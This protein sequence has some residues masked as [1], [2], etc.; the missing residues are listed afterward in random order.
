MMRNLDQDLKQIIIENCQLAILP[1]EIREDTN[2]YKDLGLDSIK[3]VN[4]ISD[5]EMQFGI[6]I[7]MDQ[8]LIDMLKEYRSLKSYLLHKLSPMEV[9]RCGK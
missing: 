3:I 8:D 5:I 4:I 6:A 9:D 1:E 2:L 7:S